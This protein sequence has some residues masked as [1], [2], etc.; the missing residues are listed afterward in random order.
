MFE[1]VITQLDAL[2]WATPLILLIFASA[3]YYTVRM[4]FV[5][6][7]DLK[8][9][10][11]LL[12]RKRDSEHGINPFEAFCTI[13]AYRVGTANIAGVCVAILWGGPGAIIWMVICS[14]LD[15]A[16]SYAECALGQVYKIKQDG[17]YRGGSYYYLERGLGLKRLATVF[18]VLTVF[19]VP[20]LNVGPHANSIALAFT[21][22]TGIPKWVFGLAIGL[23]L[24]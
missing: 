18:A 10:F 8:H 19:C 24:L 15:A 2:V 23:V 22:S 3:T 14:L 12:H 16:I 13:V 7:R 5:Q 9:Q 6:L 1:R 17:E 20:I 4:G 11:S 21:T